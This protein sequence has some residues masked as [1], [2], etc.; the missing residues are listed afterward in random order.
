M[1]TSFN[2]PLQFIKTYAKF[3]TVIV[4]PFAFQYSVCYTS[5][6]ISLK[7][8]KHRL[9]SVVHEKRKEKTQTQF[10]CRLFCSALPIFNVSFMCIILYIYI[11][12]GY[13]PHSA[14][15][16]LHMYVHTSRPFYFDI[17]VL[18]FWNWFTVYT[19]ERASLSL[20]YI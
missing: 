20:L 1:W 10:R 11:F 15:V 7:T 2:E 5:N 8:H 17:L 16:A 9:H 4:V 13:V 6:S 19:D 12:V 18:V 3:I 14:P